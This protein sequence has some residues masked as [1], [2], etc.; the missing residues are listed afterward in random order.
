MKTLLAMTAV[1]AVASSPAMAC[2]MH[3]TASHDM[4]TTA[5]VEK[6]ITM[7]EQMPA[8]VAETEVAEETTEP[9]AD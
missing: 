3:K 8:D 9:S 7:V 4:M 1:L 2:S 6:P 5:S